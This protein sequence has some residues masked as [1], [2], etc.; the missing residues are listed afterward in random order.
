MSVP[1]DRQE[2]ENLIRDIF[3]D[4]KKVLR[5]QGL[6]YESLCPFCN[7]G[8]SSEISF[9]FNL[10]KGTA[11]CWRAKCDW[12]G[13]CVKFVKDYF[14]V[15]WKSAYDMVGGTPPENLDDIL[16]VLDKYELNDVADYKDFELNDRIYEWPENT[17]PLFKNGDITQI[18]VDDEIYLQIYDWIERVRGYNPN[19]F[20]QQHNLY[21]PQQFGAY[22]GRV[23][24]EVKSQL[25]VAYL[26]YAFDSN[27][28]PKTLNPRGSILSNM[29]Y[30]YN[31]ARHGETI[32]V[33]EGLFDSARLKSYGFHA[34]S[35]FG[36]NLSSQQL[37]LLDQ[38]NAKEIVICLDYGMDIKSQFLVKELDK[39]LEDKSVSYL[40]IE[41]ENADPD[42]LSE[43]EF[44]IYYSRRKKLK[45]PRDILDLLEDL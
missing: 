42:D 13:S 8:R 43:E 18:N 2:L 45:K 39:Y 35:I 32:F 19:Q 30:N 14:K 5:G 10:D 15:P 23:L 24:F 29:L 40:S 44:L 22:E 9:N 37:L 11:R 7:G 25:D 17:K 34:V 6:E 28:T 36:T 21:V 16:A 3:P 33:C 31:D 4:A 26:A 41:K 12:R 27:V 1:Y 20:F 38:T